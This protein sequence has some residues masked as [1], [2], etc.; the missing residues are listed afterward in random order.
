MVYELHVRDFS[1]SDPSVPSELRGK[2]LAFARE[3]TRC[4]KH[5]RALAAAGVTHVRVGP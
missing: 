1:A 4:D 2:Y 5:L 3:G